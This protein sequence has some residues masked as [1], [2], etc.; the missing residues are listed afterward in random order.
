MNGVNIG[1][2]YFITENISID[3]KTSYVRGYQITNASKH[4]TSPNLPDIPPLREVLS[5]R[6]DNHKYFGEI[7][8]ILAS[9]QNNVNTDLKEQKVPGY[10]L[11]NLKGGFNYKNISFTLG[12]DNV[13][14]QE[15]YS[16]NDYY[17]NP[18]NQGIKLPEP[19]RTFYTNISYSF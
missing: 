13:L 2:T 17:S 5:L 14:N 10:A 12:V 6:Y 18:F 9:T 7:Q 4:I 19:G 16:Y 15:Y 3:S 11:L 1:A 8:T